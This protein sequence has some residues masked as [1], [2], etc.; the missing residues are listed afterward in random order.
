MDNTFEVL[1]IT[2]LV[3]IRRKAVS[4]SVPAESG[5]MCTLA[6]HAPI[7]ANLV[8]GKITLRSAGHSVAQHWESKGKGFFKFRDNAATVI[9]DSFK[10][11]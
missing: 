2:P 7:L 9:L 5:Y 10:P 11:E 1:I 6:R 8:P 3:S 4:L